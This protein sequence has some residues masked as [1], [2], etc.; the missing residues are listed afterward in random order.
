MSH[1]KTLLL[2]T[3]AKSQSYNKI[4]KNSILS[5]ISICDGGNHRVTSYKHQLHSIKRLKYRVY[6]YSFTSVLHLIA[7]IPSAM[8][9]LS[10][11]G[12]RSGSGGEEGPVSS[13]RELTLQGA[14]KS[15]VGVLPSSDLGLVGGGG[16]GGRGGSLADGEEPDGGRSK[17]QTGGRSCLWWNHHHHGA[18]P[19][20][21]E[22]GDLPRLSRPPPRLF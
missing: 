5:P 6:F 15:W 19:S 16:A 9:V 3:R 2:L 17:T 11:P 14:G 21:Q 12:R 18:A 20:S 10:H 22:P 8:L 13:G 1:R 7:A 4:I